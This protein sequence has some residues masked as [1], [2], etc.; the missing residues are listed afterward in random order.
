MHT[1]SPLDLITLVQSSG[2]AATSGWACG[3]EGAL[4][5]SC[6]ASQG[7]DQTPG[8]F[9]IFSFELRQPLSDQNLFLSFS[10]Y[11]SLSRLLPLSLA[12]PVHVPVLVCSGRSGS[13]KVLR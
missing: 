12:V 11:L 4:A 8:E 3:S 6:R 2:R 9:S 13:A 10:L 5:P 1:Y 7:H